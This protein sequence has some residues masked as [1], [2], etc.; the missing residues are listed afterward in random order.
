MQNLYIKNWSKIVLTGISS[1]NYPKFED[2]FIEG[3]HWLDS[4]Y[5]LN[6]TKC[7]EKRKNWLA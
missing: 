7:S 1:I 2:F 6:E 5:N 3:F 4:K